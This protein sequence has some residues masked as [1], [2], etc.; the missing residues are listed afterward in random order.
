MKLLDL[1]CFITQ[2]TKVNKNHK[3]DLMVKSL[4]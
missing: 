4:L 2:G 3:F 1:K